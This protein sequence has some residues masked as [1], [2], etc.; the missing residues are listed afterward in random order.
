MGYEDKIKDLEIDEAKY[1]NAIAKHKSLQNEIEEYIEDR[2]E[3]KNKINELN[4]EMSEIQLHADELR[5]Q[6]KRDS[7]NIS[8]LTHCNDDLVDILHECEDFLNEKGAKYLS[9]SVIGT[10]E[11]AL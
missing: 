8:R 5:K 9:V 4:Q 2:T 10:Q 3:L 7:L 11:L 6:S 1:A